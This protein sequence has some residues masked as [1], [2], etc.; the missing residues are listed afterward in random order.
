MEF[1]GLGELGSGL[2]LTIA[3]PAPA[4]IDLNSFGSSGGNDGSSNENATEL[5]L[6]DTFNNHSQHGGQEEDALMRSGVDVEGDAGGGSFVTR[7]Q[8][9]KLSKEQSDELDA[10]FQQNS[11]IDKRTKEAL[12]ERLKITPK[13]VDV[14]FLNRRS[15]LRK[16]QAEE[17]L[18]QHKKKVEEL[19]KQ[20]DRLQRKIDKLKKRNKE[21]KAK[22]KEATTPKAPPPPPP[23]PSPSVMLVPLPAG[24]NTLAGLYPGFEGKV[25]DMAAA[26][27]AALNTQQGSA[28]AAAL[29]SSSAPPVPPSDGR[30]SI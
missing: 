26:A 23:Q 11:F 5:A 17:D 29:P 20:K 22:L 25:T 18:M 15:R 9:R 24:L 19:T 1:N 7:T 27:A 4:G 6:V 12:A 2:E 8:Y 28:A 30:S 13:Q 16:Q 21:L 14:W 3:T 10:A